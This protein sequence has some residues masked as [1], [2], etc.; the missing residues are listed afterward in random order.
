MSNKL[1]VISENTVYKGRFFEVKEQKIV[2]PNNKKKV[3]EIVERLPTVNI[4]PL[5]GK[6]K[7]EVYLISEYRSM[8]KR[9]I[10]G[11]VAGH[12]E[13]NETTLTAAKRE[14]KEEAGI[15]AYQWEEIARFRKSNSVI[16]EMSHIFVARDLEVFSKS[17]EEGE[18]IVL[19]KLPFKEALAKV[20]NGEINDSATV[21]GMLTLE[22]LRFEKKL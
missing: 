9:R 14:L 16:K 15:V 12:V 5:V 4:F 22:R 1:K 8:L 11:A 10:L 17:P 13:K 6:H 3:Y 20:I 7:L 2:L 18:D 19:V 21:I